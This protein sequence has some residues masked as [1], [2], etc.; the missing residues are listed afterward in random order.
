M[1]CVLILTYPHAYHV[2]QTANFVAE[3]ASVQTTILP[4]RLLAIP[5]SVYQYTNTHDTSNETQSRQ[6]QTRL[7]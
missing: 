7:Q 3:R 1:I 2:P 4:D 6:Q 5:R